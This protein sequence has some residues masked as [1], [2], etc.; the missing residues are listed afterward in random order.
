VKLT[1]WPG[2]LTAAACLITLAASAAAGIAAP[3]RAATTTP[4]AAVANGYRVPGELLGVAALAPANAWAVGYTGSFLNSPKTLIVHWNGRKWLPVSSPKPLPGLLWGIAA[5]SAKDIWAVGFS[6]THVLV[7]HYNGSTWNR[8]TTVP[9]VN[10]ELTAVAVSGG[11]VWA[12]G[13]LN[14]PPVLAMR[15]TAAG[16]KVVKTPSVSGS[17]LGVAAS[18]GSVWADGTVSTD[19]TPNLGD[20][21]LHWNGSRFVQASFPLHGSDD[22]LWGLAAG[23]KGVLFAVGDHHNA[24]FS[25]YTPLSMEYSGGGWHKAAVSAPANSTLNAVGFVPEGGAWAVGSAAAYKSTLTLRWTGS[26]WSKVASPNPY[27]GNNYGVAV[28]ATSAKDAWLVGAGAKSAGSGALSTFILH[29]N[30]RSWS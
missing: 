15:R 24:S 25:G 2:K 27:A 6:G 22:N 12:T 18:G 21:L 4:R 23:P 3:A 30:G 9:A 7:M 17:L 13:G 1:S 28:A 10:G 16:W 11:T 8:D 14:N 29:W 5:A 19:A 26:A 20:T